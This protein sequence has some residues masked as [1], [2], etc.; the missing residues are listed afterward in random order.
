MEKRRLGRTN[1][2]SSV[3]IFGGAAL[4]DETPEKALSA[5]D[6]VRAHGV[7][8]FDIAP[9][10]GK[11][12]LLV[13]PWLGEHRH[14]IFLGSKT[15]ER[16][17]EGAWDELQK[18]LKLM[19]VET[20]DLYQFHSVGDMATLDQVLGAGG[21]IEAFLDA[22]EKGIIRYIGITGHGY[23]APATHAAALERFDF[24][25]VMTPLNFIEYA[26]P[27]YRADFDRLMQL[28]DAQDVGVMIIKAFSR[29]PW[30]DGKKTYNTWYEPFDEQAIMQQAVNFVL[31]HA[32]TGFTHPG[33]LRLLPMAVAA[34][35]NYRKLDDGERDALIARAENYAPLFE[36]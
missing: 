7:N 31:S 12:E 35:E 34:A 15:G 20:I 36:R 27:K 30:V 24:D 10:Y 2:E 28:A 1:Q 29:G 14:N 26:D 4:W 13:G 6:L 25:T 5:I 18:T 22:R 8:H 9:S 11:A 23:E 16:T 32:V 33:D 21:A 17:R 19:Q 3:L